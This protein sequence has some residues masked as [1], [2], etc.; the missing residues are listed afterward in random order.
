ML[1]LL[2]KFLFLLPIVGIKNY[3]AR[4]SY[5]TIIFIPSF[6]NVAPLVEQLT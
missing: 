3:G 6:M 1:I 4:L 5:T 2:H